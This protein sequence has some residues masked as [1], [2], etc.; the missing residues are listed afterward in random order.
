MP[1]VAVLLSLIVAGCSTPTL[2]QTP[3]QSEATTRPTS[4]LPSPTASTAPP[5]PEIITPSKPPNRAPSEPTITTPRDGA[6][7]IGTTTTIVITATDPDGD[8]LTFSASLVDTTTGRQQLTPCRQR[9]CTLDVT[10]GHTYA[11]TPTA[12]DG[13]IS[14]TGTPIRFTVNTPPPLP[15]ILAPQPGDHSTPPQGGLL[16]YQNQADADGD[17]VRTSGITLQDAATGANFGALCSNSPCLL[18]DL[19]PGHTYAYILTVTD[20]YES[21]TRQGTLRVNAPPNHI[22]IDDGDD[23]TTQLPLTFPLTEPFATD[24]DGDALTTEIRV[25]YARNDTPAQTCP[26]LTGVFQC[27]IDLPMWGQEYAITLT[28]RDAYGL[29][30]TRTIHVTTRLPVV[31]IHGWHGDRSSMMLAEDFLDQG[32]DAF[33]VSYAPKADETSIA[34]LSTEQVWPA[35]ERSLTAAGYPTTQRFDVVAH[36]MGGLIARYLIE[37][38]DDNTRQW[39]TRVERLVM[40]GT[41]NHGSFWASSERCAALYWSESCRE[42]S[43]GS[44]FLSN[45]GIPT[46]PTGYSTIAGYGHYAYHNDD[47]G[48]VSRN[49]VAIPGAKN[50]EQRG[51]CHATRWF[52]NCAEEDALMNSERVLNDLTTILDH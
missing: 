5:A 21:R 40:V 49:S 3:D 15:L 44:T 43:I 37:N 46:F 36:S 23:G 27:S 16:T 11:V 7:I 28:A 4:T 25:T 10:P 24:P 13:K 38:P 19:T 48:V 9:T 20:G 35:V 45:L 39:D 41:P 14:A 26:T 47:D 34:A 31:L 17:A 33:R 8:A 51:L 29:T 12:T 32:H 50:I 18:P 1:Y 42:M 52:L 2:T 6:R 22:Q 30:A